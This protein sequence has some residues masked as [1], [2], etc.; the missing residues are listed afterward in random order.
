MIGT[1]KKRSG[2]RLERNDRLVRLAL[3]GTLLSHM[4]EFGQ[5]LRDRQSEIIAISD[6][7]EILELGITSLPMAD[8][9]PEWLAP[10]IAVIPGQLL[11]LR[12]ALAKGVNP[13]APRGLSKVTVTR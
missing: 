10:V 1:A 9:A 6:A 7:R 4:R 3:L 8:G 13:D 5:A 2:T 11:A 12:L